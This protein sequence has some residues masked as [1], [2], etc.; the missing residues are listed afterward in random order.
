MKKWATFSQL[1]RKCRGLELKVKKLGCVAARFQSERDVL[2]AK[3]EYLRT[4][5]IPVDRIVKKYGAKK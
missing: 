4:G 5:G 2:L 1:E 3:L